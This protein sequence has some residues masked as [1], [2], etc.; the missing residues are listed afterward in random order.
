VHSLVC[1]LVLI[2]C[3]YRR[4]QSL[5]VLA[6]DLVDAVTFVAFEFTSGFLVD[7]ASFFPPA[8]LP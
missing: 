6:H 5:L 1:F 3:R 2:H 4:C 8:F 7:A